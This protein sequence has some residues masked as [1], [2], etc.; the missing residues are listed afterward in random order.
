M[1]DLHVVLSGAGVCAAGV[2]SPG[3]NF[4]AVSHRAAVA[5][6]RAEV[7]ALAAGIACVN[8]LW[9]CLAVF[10]IDALTAS[11]PWLVTAL[12]AGGAAYLLW[13]GAR[14][15]RRGVAKETP[16]ASGAPAAGGLRA[17]WVDGLSTNL[18][19]P[20]AM[21]FYAAV[22]AGVVPAGTSVL[23][24]AALIATVGA[25][26]LGW[27][28]ALA[29]ALSHPAVSARLRRLRPAIDAGCGV[30]LLALGAWQLAAA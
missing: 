20:K 4:V 23:T 17:A 9:A 7:L 10:G 30:L 8:V 22:F 3:P 24:L 16:D 2:M 29:L 13:I 26:A 18:A 14:L 19:N 11:R 21:V 1:L 5:G 28:G 25:V 15:L 27:Y 6:R 12:K